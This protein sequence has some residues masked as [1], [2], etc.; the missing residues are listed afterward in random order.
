MFEIDLCPHSFDSKNICV[1]D[2]KISAKGD[3]VD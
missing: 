2:I 1:K 3:G